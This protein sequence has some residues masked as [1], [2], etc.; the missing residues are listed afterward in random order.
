VSSSD[1]RVRVRRLEGELLPEARDLR[2]RVF[3]DEQHVPAELEWDGRDA[4][5][6]QLVAT[7]DG[8]VVGVARARH[9]GGYLKAER[10]AVAAAARGAGVG[11]ALMRE[12]EALAAERRMPAVT[13][14]AQASAIA[15]Y[16]ALGYACEG[17]PF[18]EAGIEHRAMRKWL[19]G[20]P[21]TR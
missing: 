9:V 19:D 5:A 14:H 10:V 17:V 6:T 16:E 15:F 3:V 4:E 11:K 2:R 1:A 18:D 7:R 20:P 13:L 21:G 12:I 8:E